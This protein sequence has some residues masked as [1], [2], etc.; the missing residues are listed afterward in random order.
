MGGGEGR[1]KIFLKYFLKTLL[2]TLRYLVSIRYYKTIT[3]NPARKNVRNQS[4]RN[5]S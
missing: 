1:E 4:E 2:V 5:P 3:R